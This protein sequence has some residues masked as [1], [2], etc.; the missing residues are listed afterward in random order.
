MLVLASS[1]TIRAALLERAGVPLTVDPAR[2]DEAA[3]KAALLAEAAPAR[4]IA[5]ALAA[6]KAQKV[7]GRHPGALVLG[8]DQVLVADGRLFDK[9]QDQD[10]ARDQ[11]QALRGRRHQ[12]LS[13]AVIACDGAPVW[14]HIGTADMEMR[15]FSD[16]FLEDYILR[17]G[18]GLTA[19]VGCY[20]LEEDG[21]QLFSRIA[22]DYFSILGLP[23]L[24][25]LSF[26]RTRGLLGE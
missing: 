6:L 13:A 26:L 25:V 23:L 17:H 21:P 11:L 15:D 10:V 24:Q 4:D 14:R 18:D 1:S 5:D 2:V 7:S 8:A 20:K 3:V 16:A 22:G 12:L 19:T 9:P